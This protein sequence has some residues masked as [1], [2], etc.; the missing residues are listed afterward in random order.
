MVLVLVY[1]KIGRNS[2]TIEEFTIEKTWIYILGLAVASK[3]I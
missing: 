2:G 3:V 1:V